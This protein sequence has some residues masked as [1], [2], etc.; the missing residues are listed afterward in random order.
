MSAHLF[1]KSL[2]PMT[3]GGI[4]CCVCLKLMCLSS[5]AIN[6][7][8]THPWNC[9]HK[10]GSVSLISFWDTGVG[11]PLFDGFRRQ[12][13][14]MCVRVWG[15]ISKKIL[16]IIL[17]VFCLITSRMDNFYVAEFVA[18][19]FWEFSLARTVWFLGALRCGST[20]NSGCKNKMRAVSL[21]L[22]VAS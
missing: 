2:R 9:R 12:G 21:L 14:L 3:S 6:T 1:I 20:A 4:Q 7:R 19:K 15:K 8:C 18:M 10:M 16:L 11:D 13:S 5:A 17:I 22:F